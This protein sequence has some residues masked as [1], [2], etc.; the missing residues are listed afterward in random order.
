MGGAEAVSWLFAA[1]LLGGAT[2]L[3]ASDRLRA[4]IWEGG[5]PGQ[6]GALPTEEVAADAAPRG[7]KCAQ[8]LVSPDAQGVR[9]AGVAIGGI[10]E[11]DDT[12]VCAFNRDHEVPSLACEC[13]FYAFAERDRAAELLACAVG[14]G[15]NVVVRAVLEVD[16]LGTV[17][18]CERGYRAE[19]QRVLGVGLLPWCADCAFR[20]ELVRARVVG[21]TPR[22]PMSTLG[23]RSYA[24]QAAVRSVH[25]SVR[26]RLSWTVLRPMCRLCLAALGDRVVH[27]DLVEVSNRLGT[28]VSWLDPELVPAERVLAGHRPR[29]PWG[30]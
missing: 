7:W 15:G 5:L 13:G 23:A 6:F 30:A 25:P 19:H 21:G 12:A 18:E 11:T 28:E 29:P 14:V 2:A 8:L 4:F 1:L 9:L 10:Y 27:L 16:L 24:Q 3:W 17:I 26:Q 22:P 20:G